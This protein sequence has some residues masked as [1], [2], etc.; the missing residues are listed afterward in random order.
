MVSLGVKMVRLIQVMLLVPNLVLS[1]GCGP[2]T[3]P[4]CGLQ[5]CRHVALDFISAAGGL[6]FLSSP[7]LNSSV[8]IDLEGWLNSCGVVTPGGPA[9]KF[10][11]LPHPY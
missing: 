10:P 6:C 1:P 9:G 11:F 5:R 7:N 3:D 2:D 4:T 8:E